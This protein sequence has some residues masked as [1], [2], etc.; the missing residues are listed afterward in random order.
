MHSIAKLHNKTNID[1]LIFYL[2]VNAYIL[3]ELAF[4]S[5]YVRAN[6]EAWEALN[7]KVKFWLYNIVK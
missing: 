1:L 6:S 4:H 2:K 7:L 3:P 5:F